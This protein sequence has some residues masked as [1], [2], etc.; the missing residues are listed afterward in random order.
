VGASSALYFNSLYYCPSDWYCS[1]STSGRTQPELA[2]NADDFIDTIGVNTHLF[3]DNSVYYQKYKEIIKPKL[4]ELG[5]RH[6][7]DGGTLNRNGYLDRLKELGTLGIQSTLIFDPRNSTPQGAVALIKEL[8]MG[9]VEAAQGPNEYDNSGDANWVSTLRTYQQQLYRAIRGDSAAAAL[10]VY[11]PTLTSA[12]AYNSIGDLSSVVDYAAMSNYYSGRNPGTSGWGDQG[13]GSIGWNV[14]LAHKYSG[15]KSVVST[16]AGYHN[17]VSTTDGHIGVPEDVSGKYIPR[18]YL[19]HFNYGIPRTLIYEL[20]NVYN[21]PNNWN[22]NFGLLRNNGSEKPAFSTQN[23]ISLLKDPG[24][25]FTPRAL[26]YVLSG[27]TTNVHHTLLE[28]R[29]GTFYL[30]LWQEVSSFN[31]NSKQNINVSSQQV[32]LT[33]NQP[34]ESATIYLPNNSTASIEQDSNPNQIN[35]NVPDYP[36]VVE[37]KN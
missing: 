18:I 16:E 11:G 32:T 20:I 37:L 30:I 17:M 19:E 27:N 26:D 12:E 35:L 1:A 7:R 25:N 5:V 36:L 34:I 33:L 28:K 8:G 31:V 2:R 14:Q 4:L 9:V 13:Y 3:Y 29:S 21:E 23:L 22:K 6:I 15:S 24:P 10:P